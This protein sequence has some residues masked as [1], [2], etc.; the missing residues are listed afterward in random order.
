MLPTPCLIVLFGIY[1]QIVAGVDNSPGV[2][3]T[4]S[5]SKHEADNVLLS[6]VRVLKYVQ[7]ISDLTLDANEIL[8]NVDIC[9]RWPRKQVTRHPN[10]TLEPGL[11]W[12]FLKFTARIRKR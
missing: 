10:S 12:G 5:K 2:D 1:R 11:M 7:W 4:L 9:Y 8:E 6:Q 3:H